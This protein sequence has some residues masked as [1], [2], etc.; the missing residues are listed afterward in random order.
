MAAPSDSSPP[1]ANPLKPGEPGLAPGRGQAGP[2][3]R[4]PSAKP[5]AVNS[6]EALAGPAF[7]AAVTGACNA[8]SVI[9]I[10]RPRRP[11]AA[12]TE[13]VSHRGE[14]GFVPVRRDSG[15]REGRGPAKAGQ[16]AGQIA[17]QRSG[18]REGL[19]RAA[20]RVVDVVIRAIPEQRCTIPALVDQG[21]PG[22]L[23]R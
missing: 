10:A 23:C 16:P 12:V 19:R 1:E 22:T 17:E 3:G 5:R 6:M 11:S 13:D 4:V 9:V 15:G 2:F 20:D 18:R 8:H 14:A 21:E 7:R